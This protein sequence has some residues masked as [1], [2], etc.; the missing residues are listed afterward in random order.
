MAKRKTVLTVRYLSGTS[1]RGSNR[2]LERASRTT[3]KSHVGILGRTGGLSLLIP[4]RNRISSGFFPMDW[5]PTGEWWAAIAAM[6]TLSVDADSPE[7]NLSC[8]MSSHD[9]IEHSTGFNWWLLQQDMKSCHLAAYDFLVAGALD[10]RMVSTTSVDR[11][12]D[13][14]CAPSGATPTASTTLGE[15]D[16]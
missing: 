12:D 2:A 10:C 13:M 11:P 7:A 14:R 15:G 3:A 4:R 9:P 6:Y 1:S 5:S 16:I 8:R